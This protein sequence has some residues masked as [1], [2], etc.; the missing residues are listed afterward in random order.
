MARPDIFGRV[1]QLVAAGLVADGVPPMT[2]ILEAGKRPRCSVCGSKDE[3]L[4]E[5]EDEQ[6][7]GWAELNDMARATDPYGAA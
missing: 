3:H 6:A 2:P 7:G 1:V 5:A 4:A